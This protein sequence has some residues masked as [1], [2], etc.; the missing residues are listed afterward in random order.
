MSSGFFRGTSIQQDGRFANK[1]KQLLRTMKFPK[2][3]AEPV[4]MKNVNIPAIMPWVASRIVAL[5]GFEDEVVIGYVRSQLEQEQ[6][7]AA[8]RAT[9]AVG[10]DHRIF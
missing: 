8:A 9:Q 1:E 4:H 10:L 2:N 5:L 7:R 6:A 3:F